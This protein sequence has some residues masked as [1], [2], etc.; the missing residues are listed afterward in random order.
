[1]RVNADGP[2]LTPAALD[3]ALADKFGSDGQ[4]VYQSAAALIAKMPDVGREWLTSTLR[5]LD[6]HS[7]TVVIERLARTASA[8]APKA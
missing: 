8:N 2:E 3:E 5:G 7:A 4:A 1:M 6:A